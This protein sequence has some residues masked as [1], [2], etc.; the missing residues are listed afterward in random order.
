MVREALKFSAKLRLSGVDNQQMEE[1]VD[2][3]RLR[4][5]HVSTKCGWSTLDSTL[6]VFFW[7]DLTP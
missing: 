7:L 3:V 1:F 5:L 6:Q 4:I 2:E